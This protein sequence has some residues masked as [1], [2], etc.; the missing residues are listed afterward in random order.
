MFRTRRQW[1]D[2]INVVGARYVDVW[3]VINDW[4]SSDLTL[5][6]EIGK[7]KELTDNVNAAFNDLRKE[8]NSEH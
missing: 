3:A 1:T 2:H 8:Y 7:L 5:E 4:E 6:K